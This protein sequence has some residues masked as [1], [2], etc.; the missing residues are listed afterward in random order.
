MKDVSR[1]DNLPI[2]NQMYN[3]PINTSNINAIDDCMFGNVNITHNN[4][5]A[6]Q[7]T[8]T[9]ETINFMKIF[10]YFFNKPL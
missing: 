10:I 3:A 9:N 1:N 6:N 5:N 8:K 4:I 7:N 2:K